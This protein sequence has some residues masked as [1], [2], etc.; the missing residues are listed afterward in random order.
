MTG[1]ADAVRT[2]WNPFSRVVPERRVSARR[3]AVAPRIHSPHLSQRIDR[4][5]IATR[6]LRPPPPPLTMCHPRLHNAPA[7]VQP[8]YVRSHRLREERGDT[9]RD[10]CKEQ[11][12]GGAGRVGAGGGRVSVRLKSVRKH[13]PP[14]RP[15]LESEA[16]HEGPRGAKTWIEEGYGSVFKALSDHSNALLWAFRFD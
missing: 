9:E 8:P 6:T 1:E 11:G 14:N 15:A 10:E 4:G 7:D 13:F 2:G 5:A 16:G 3:I 12:P